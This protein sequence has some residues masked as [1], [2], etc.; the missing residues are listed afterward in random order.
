MRNKVVLVTGAS[1]GIG[2]GIA[3]RF[4][5]QGCFLILV[6]RSIRNFDQD[7]IDDPNSLIVEA[8]VT[9]SKGIKNVYDSLRILKRNLDVLI[10]NV[11][12]G[13]SS[14]PGSETKSDWVKAFDINF[15]S[16]V[17]IIS[18]LRG[19]LSKRD[20]C[21]LCISS[22]CGEV[23]IRSAPITYSAAKAALNAYIKGMSIPL[24][25]DGIRING[26]ALGNILHEN[27]VWYRKQL[28]D[29]KS[30]QEYLDKEVVLKRLGLPDEVAKMALWLAS[31]NMNFATGTIF[32][33]DGGQAL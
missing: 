5:Q 23:V 17:E 22:I 26:I 21:V 25:K 2:K 28:E 15:Y 9:T 7:V 13:S 29:Q 1:K 8:D 4:L 3:A 10:C 31:D 14:A 33:L 18:S 12:S 6:S 11:G 30:L 32:R 19:Y 24:A 16:A 27:S 20:G